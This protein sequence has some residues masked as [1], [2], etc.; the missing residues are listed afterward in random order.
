MAT[1]EELDAVARGGSQ[2]RAAYAQ[3]QELIASQRK[4]AIGAALAEAAQRGAPAG[5]QDEI[6]TT[7]GAPYDRQIGNLAQASASR[8]AELDQL[9][10]G[11]AAYMSQVAAA[12]PAMRGALERRLAAKRAGGG[13]GELSDSE[14]S[15]RLIGAA[16]AER[17]PLEAEVAPTQAA[18][19]QVKAKRWGTAYSQIQRGQKG[20][21]LAGR[22]VKIN[23]QLATPVE[24]RARQLGVAAGIDQARA[25]G[26]VPDPDPLT[27]Q[28]EASRLR[29]VDYLDQRG[30]PKPVA[31]PI[32]K[33][34]GVSE[35]E[36]A[37]LRT[38]S[39]YKK[40]RKDAELARQ[41]ARSLDEL[42]ALLNTKYK[43]RTLTRLVLEEYRPLLVGSG[44]EPG[45]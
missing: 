2:G 8:T 7:V 26:V 10:V 25:Y 28:D 5:M 9:S 3:A 35:P 34:I 17:E 12:G 19:D 18:L 41:G 6:S 40:M 27:V 39:T 15:K 33:S 45:S 16:R 4:A 42:K 20:G 44:Y 30:K 29:A 1:R 11:N 14:L 13:G 24:T 43:G 32:A 31:D 37:R 22:L 23:E 38:T 36:V 21:A